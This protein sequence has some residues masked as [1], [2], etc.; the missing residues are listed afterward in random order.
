MPLTEDAVLRPDVEFVYARQLATVEA[1]VDRWRRDDPERAVA[2]L[3]PV[4]AMAA[5]GTSSLARGARRRIRASASA[6]T[7]RRRSSSTS[8][9]SPRRSLLAVDQR[10]DGVFNVAPD[11]WVAGRAS[12]CTDR[13]HGPA[14]GCRIGSPRSSAGCAGGSSVARS[15]PV[16]AATRAHRGWSPTTA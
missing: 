3:R 10:L 9:T 6:K 12:T 14:S 1:M 8:T 13:R 5:D 7:I 16:C 4:V 11:G 2:V 15:R